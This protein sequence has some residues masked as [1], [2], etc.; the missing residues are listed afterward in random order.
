MTN[1]EKDS[2][3]RTFNNA[4]VAKG[5]LLDEGYKGDAIRM[6][7]YCLSWSFPLLGES[8]Q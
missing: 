3:L 1:D 6:L 5:I 7:D 8:I 2:L 4:A